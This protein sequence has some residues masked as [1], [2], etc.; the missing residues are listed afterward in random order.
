MGYMGPRHPAMTTS[1]DIRDSCTDGGYSL[2]TSSLDSP[3]TSL[4][5]RVTHRFTEMAAAQSSM[6]KKP[7]SVIEPSRREALGGRNLQGF[8]G[9]SAYLKAKAM[10]AVSVPP[11]YQ[12]GKK[13][14]LYFNVLPRIQLPPLLL[15]F[16]Y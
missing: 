10:K 15:L 12:G 2:A 4:P 13:K 3:A 7:L 5:S 9:A 1:G 6:P 16:K 8:P 11:N 14:I